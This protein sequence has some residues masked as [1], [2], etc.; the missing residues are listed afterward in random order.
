MALASKSQDSCSR[1]KSQI[2]A[3]M[4]RVS[5]ASRE[6]H[7]CVTPLTVT[8]VAHR[9]EWMRAIQTVANSL[10]NQEPE[11]DVMDYKCGS[12]NDSAG[13]EEMEVAVTKTRVKAVRGWGGPSL[14]GGGLYPSAGEGGLFP[15]L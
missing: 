10:K 7:P 11:E 5:S 2:Q 9:E 8:S 12:P 3:A 1:T 6:A 14:D 4:L 13:A 15:E